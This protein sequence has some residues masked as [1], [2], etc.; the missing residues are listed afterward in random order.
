MRLSLDRSIL[1]IRNL[2][3][4]PRICCDC[5]LASAAVELPL[6]G[7]KRPWA[8]FHANQSGKEPFRLRGHTGG[9]RAFLTVIFWLWGLLGLL[10][11]GGTLMGLTGAIGVGTSAYFTASSMIWIGGMALFGLGALLSH[12]DFNGERP[13]PPGAGDIHISR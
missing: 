1:S 4:R 5:H 11:N 9:G 7:G 8:Y 10:F 6:Y 3:P 2:R 12:T 13:L